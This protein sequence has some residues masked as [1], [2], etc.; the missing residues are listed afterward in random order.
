VAPVGECLTIVIV[1]LLAEA[2]SREGEI[3]W[4]LWTCRPEAEAKLKSSM[5]MGSALGRSP[6]LGS[7]MGA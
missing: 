2:Q 1:L 4:M 7:L 6:Q 5:M 3:M